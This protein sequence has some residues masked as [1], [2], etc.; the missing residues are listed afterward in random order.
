MATHCAT[1]RQIVTAPYFLQ[2]PEFQAAEPTSYI[3]QAFHYI[4]ENIAYENETIS[5]FRNI[6]GILPS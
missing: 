6:D 3:W 4:I 5:Y 2:L 1:A